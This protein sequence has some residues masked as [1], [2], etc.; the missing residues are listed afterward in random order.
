MVSA[1]KQKAVPKQKNETGQN[2][3][4]RRPGSQPPLWENHET[5]YAIHQQCIAVIFRRTKT[6]CW[7]PLPSF[8]PCQGYGAMIHIRRSK[9]VVP[10]DAMKPCREGICITPMILKFGS[11]CWMISFTPRSRCPLDRTLLPIDQEAGFSSEPVCTIWRNEESLA[12]GGIQ[13]ANLQLVV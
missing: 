1:H 11:R 8:F 13:T 9:A 7:K 12:P 6:A 5:S 4:T 10:V 2:C 3:W